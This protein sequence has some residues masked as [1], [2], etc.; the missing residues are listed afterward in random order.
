MRQLVDALPAGSYVV[1]TNYWN[2]HNGGPT[3]SLA[4]AVQH[5][6]LERLGS[7]WFRSR[8]TIA[9]YLDGLH[10][11]PPA[12]VTPDQWWPAGPTTCPVSTAEKLILAGI[13]K[14]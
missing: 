11:L 5:H 7:G 13:A 3:E 4:T 2:P 8:T 1:F 10:V 6:Y 12:L 9:S 14:C